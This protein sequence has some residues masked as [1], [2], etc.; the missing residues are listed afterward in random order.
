MVMNRLIEAGAQV[1][2]QSTDIGYTPLIWA[3]SQGST[4]QVQLLLEFGADPQLWDKWGQTALDRCTEKPGAAALLKNAMP[5][6]QVEQLLE[7]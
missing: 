3:A 7:E 4:E 2:A 1:N 6:K 5:P